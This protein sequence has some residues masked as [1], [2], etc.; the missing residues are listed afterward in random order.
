MNINHIIVHSIEKE[1]HQTAITLH[2]RTEEL[3]VDDKVVSLLE[4]V[5]SVY[6][7][8]TGKAFGMLG[9]NRSFSRELKKFQQDEIEF[10][11]FTNVAMNELKGHMAQEP[12][13]TGGYLLFSDFNN[14]GKHYFMVIM[15]KSKDGLS[16]D[17]ELKLMD[18]HHLELDKLHFAARVDVDSW[19]SDAGE[20]NVSFVKGRASSA[21]TTYFKEFLGVEEFSESAK[22]T[23]TL[24]TAVINYCRQELELDNEATESYKIT[25]HDYCKS[26]HANEEPIF[27]DELS[28][29]LDEETPSAFMEYAQEKYEIPNEFQVDIGK[30]RKFLRY[31]GYD[32]D[33]RISFTSEIFGTRVKYDSET[34]VLTIKQPP[35]SL[36]KQ[37]VAEMQQE[38]DVAGQD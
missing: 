2:L 33:V 29:F 14:N 32:K 16:F 10:I 17:D 12:L 26:K 13:A 38:N 30:L 24:V 22:T 3:Q 9:I 21:V 5:R 6:T 18:A 37:L 15:L 1:Q 20:N 35:N 28:R 25:V 7:N 11:E 8:K 36:K 4:G 19:L 27:L 23:Q 31:A 34:D